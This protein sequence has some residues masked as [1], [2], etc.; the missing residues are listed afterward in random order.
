MSLLA[1]SMRCKVHTTLYQTI[2]DL[3]GLDINLSDRGLTVRRAQ[4]YRGYETALMVAILHRNKPFIKMLMDSA[5]FRYIQQTY[6]DS[7]RTHS[8]YNV[9]I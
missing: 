4:R 1:I 3:V 8:Y 5:D 2:Y 9:C 7:L 6:H